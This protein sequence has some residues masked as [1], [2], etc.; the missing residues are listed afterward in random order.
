MKKMKVEGS[1]ITVSTPGPTPVAPDFKE[2]VMREI[3]LLHSRGQIPPVIYSRAVDMLSF[4]APSMYNMYGH[5]VQGLQQ[6]V[7][8][9]LKQASRR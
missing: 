8:F 9:L 7:A 4:L 3:G 2:M 6:A 1:S 5:R